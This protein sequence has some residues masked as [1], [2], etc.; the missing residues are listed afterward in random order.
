MADN[1]KKKN[2][3]TDIKN[4][5]INIK[6]KKEIINDLNKYKYSELDILRK[7]LGIN[8][9]TN[10]KQLIEEIIRKIDYKNIDNNIKQPKKEEKETCKHYTKHIEAN[11]VNKYRKQ[12]YNKFIKFN[13]N[14]LSMT[15]NDLYELFLEYDKVFFQGDISDYLKKA[16]ISLKFMTD[17][18]HTFTTEGICL[19]D[20]C[21]YSVIIPTKFFK[22]ANGSTNVAGHICK[23]QLEC[24]QRVMEHE[25]THLII[26]IFCE[27][28]DI[29]KQHGK[30]FMKLVSDLFRHTD[31]RH[32]LF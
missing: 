5:D 32:Y 7:H 10:K 26:F 29:S 22:N 9:L 25:M 16:K 8:P 15:S 2:T 30:F 19:F 31:H 12:I 13:D 24:L 28:V 4:T 21:N 14:V 27:D 1:T 3:D 11:L 6:L 23:N 20:N 18:N 17:G